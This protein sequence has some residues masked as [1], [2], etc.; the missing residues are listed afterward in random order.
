MDASEDQV[1]SFVEMCIAVYQTDFSATQ[2]ILETLKDIF[3]PPLVP[4]GGFQLSPEASTSNLAAFRASAA[5]IVEACQ[6]VLLLIGFL[7]E[8]RTIGTWSIPEVHLYKLQQDVAKQVSHS[9]VIWSG[10][11]NFCTR[12]R[13][14][15]AGAD[16]EHQRT[17]SG[18]KREGTALCRVGLSGVTLESSGACSHGPSW[19]A[20]R[21]GMCLCVTAAAS[22]RM[23]G[24]QS[25]FIQAEAALRQAAITE[26]LVITPSSGAPITEASLEL[27]QLDLGKGHPRPPTQL[28]FRERPLAELF[29]APAEAAGDDSA[30]STSLVGLCTGPGVGEGFQQTLFSQVR[31]GARPLCNFRLAA[32]RELRHGT[33]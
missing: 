25:L 5:A 16:C 3:E 20:S 8:L 12:R 10:D 6:G 32:P 24:L 11:Y 22:G 31:E 2:V 1:A 4:F 28:H 14:R 26:W 7:L 9:T 15:P 21:G 18:G 13:L 17:T 33:F 30:A 23:P 27:T 29:G 19:S